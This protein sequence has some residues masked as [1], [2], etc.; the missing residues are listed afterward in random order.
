MVG[1]QL[2]LCRGTAGI[3]RLVL[4]STS[5][6]T[7][8]FGEESLRLIRILPPAVCDPILE[9][10]E[11]KRYDDLAFVAA[12]MEFYRRHVCRLDP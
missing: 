10:S 12:S 4:A 11:A 1:L 2:S 3:G 9:L 7:R 5:A 8:Q 6:S